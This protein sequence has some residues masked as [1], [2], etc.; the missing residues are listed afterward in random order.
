MHKLG[1]TE[2][3]ADKF[4]QIERVGCEVQIQWGRTGTSGQSQVKQFGSE[5]EAEQFLEQML[6]AKL[7]KGYLALGPEANEAA[8]AANKTLPNPPPNTLPKMTS[9]T[10]S[11]TASKPPSITTSPLPSN[12]TPKPVSMPALIP[13]INWTAK[14]REKE[15]VTQFYK[16]TYPGEIVVLKPEADTTSAWKS[17]GPELEKALQNIL[18]MGDTTWEELG[19]EMRNLAISVSPQQLSRESAALIMALSRRRQ[20]VDFL[21]QLLGPEACLQAWVASLYI[22]SEVCYNAEHKRY[23]TEIKRRN[24]PA[25]LSERE[26]GNAKIWGLRAQIEKLEPPAAEALAHSLEDLRSKAQLSLRLG[27][28]WLFYNQADWQE[29]DI[30]AWLALKPSTDY[31]LWK[32]GWL[33]WPWLRNPELLDQMAENFI[34]LAKAHPDLWDTLSLIHEPALFWLLERAG[35]GATQSLYAWIVAGK[36][37][38][39]RK[40][41]VSV[42]KLIQSEAAFSCWFHLLKHKDAGKE[43][44][45]QLSQNPLIGIKILIQGLHKRKSYP[46]AESLLTGLLRSVS[47]ESL[48]TLKQEY[49]NELGRF[50]PEAPSAPAAAALPSYFKSENWQF[51][52]E[53]CKSWPKFN[54]L[55]LPLSPAKMD[56]SRPVLE[57][58]SEFRPYIYDKPPLTDKRDPEMLNRFSGFDHVMLHH[59]DWLSDTAALKFWNETPCSRWNP[60]DPSSEDLS[61]LAM[62]FG[63]AGLPGFL[64]LLN[65]FPDA[66]YPTLCY[67][68]TP[69]V[70]PVLL[71]GLTLAS[72]RGI[73]NT[74]FLRHPA[75]ALRGLI[76]LCLNPKWGLQIEAL[77]RVIQIISGTESQTAAISQVEFQSLKTEFSPEVQLAMDGL[78]GLDPFLLRPG[79][80]PKLPSFWKPDQLPPVRLKSGESLPTESLDILALTLML[81]SPGRPYCGI[82]KVRQL[83]SPES[84]EAFV[85]GLFELWLGDGGSLKQEWA[86]WGLAHWGAEEAVRQ[87][88]PRL[89]KWPGERSVQRALLG[90]ELLFAMENVENAWPELHRL[91]LKT[92]Y[93]SVQDKAA[94]LMRKLAQE[95]PEGSEGLGDRLVPKYGLDH[96]SGRDFDLGEGQ[97]LR[98]QISA[99]GV[100]ELFDGAGKKRPKM[101][102]KGE[103]KALKNLKQA[104]K[105]LEKQIAFQKLRLERAM[106]QGRR[107]S[108]QA[109]ESTLLNHPLLK[110]LVFGLVWGIYL[111]GEERPNR[112]VCLN[113]EGVF[114]DLNR[115]PVNLT[116]GQ[117]IGLV[118]PVEILPTLQNWRAFWAQE[119]RVQPFE[120]LE[121]EI[122]IPT[123]AELN[124]TRLPDPGKVASGKVLALINDADWKAPKNSEGLL[125]KELGRGLLA[126]LTL[127][128]HLWALKEYPEVEVFH[129]LLRRSES[130]GEVRLEEIHPIAYSE[131]RRDLARLL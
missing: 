20:A 9:K 14:L 6:K 88:V 108:V 12:L 123:L 53:I 28:D 101:P 111:A 131:L 3:N 126:E 118:H 83:C 73:C 66:T 45:L 55:E 122:F 51:S 41:A 100:L 63:I 59:L 48:M 79:K 19:K 107:W 125:C 57:S 116:L 2:G 130:Y 44:H 58:H 72:Q 29:T 78:V 11:K 67:F 8:S 56:F 4:W 106:Y 37:A 42:L 22:H 110:P 52:E 89:E 10:T 21:W 17:L 127:E 61:K 75:T 50:L 120:Q 47:A 98:L 82:E 60:Y 39:I 87:L 74:W 85:L 115:Q 23:V 102:S 99:G 109:F 114:V 86:F 31:D 68:D 46:E 90:L 13:G 95:N 69:G 97:G 117:E 27:L 119:L 81:D 113:S 32:S 26:L 71:K 38:A 103:P 34:S 105:E 36:R 104:Q 24:F 62:R 80:R 7:K 25:P 124:K 49:G 18:W 121:R 77:R 40:K 84:L 94:Q 16:F 30:S 54:D 64:G 128:Y 76:P 70:V 91:S 92:R 1:Y 35:Q 43:A 5:T 93:P 65:K 129:V 33:L 112:T 15:L 96:A